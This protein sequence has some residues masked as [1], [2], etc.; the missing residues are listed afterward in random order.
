M[1]HNCNWTQAVIIKYK[2]ENCVKMQHMFIMIGIVFTLPIAKWNGNGTSC[3][4]IAF[5][6]NC[7]NSNNYV[8]MRNNFIV[9]SHVS[10][11]LTKEV[12]RWEFMLELHKYMNTHKINSRQMQQGDRSYV[13][14]AKKVLMWCWT[15]IKRQCQNYS[16]PQC[17]FWYNVNWSI[18]LVHCYVKHYCL[19]HFIFQ[20][21]C[22]ITHWHHVIHLAVHLHF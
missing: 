15:A 11:Y 7:H 19:L 17:H 6:E 4:N 12:M 18:T 2:F 5:A 1:Q 20:K 16:V 9:R 13:H 3:H 14:D 10:T 22:F 8:R 21:K